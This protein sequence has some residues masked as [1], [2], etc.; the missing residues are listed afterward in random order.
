[1]EEA[2]GG[3]LQSEAGLGKNVRPNLKI[4]KKPKACSELKPQCHQ[5]TVFLTQSCFKNSEVC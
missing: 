5:K 1:M 3:G 2:V 4:M